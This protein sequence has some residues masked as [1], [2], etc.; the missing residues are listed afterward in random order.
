[1]RLRVCVFLA[2]VLLF[3]SLAVG[4][5]KNKK[6]MVLPG[7]VLQARTVMVVVN[8]EAGI[9]LTDP[10]GNRIARM[11][12]E[13]ALSKWGRF[14][15]ICDVRPPIWSSLSVRVPEKWLPQLSAAAAQQSPGDYG[16]E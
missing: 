4:K 14:T 11:D 16:A 15:P 2:L 13:N 9:P 8:P 12:V 1:M 10:R 3:A 5:D 7:D 6:K